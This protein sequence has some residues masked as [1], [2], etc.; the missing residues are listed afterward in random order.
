MQRN[1]NHVLHA[2]V[3]V[4]R[5]VERSLLV[6]DA[7]TR[8]VGA[9]LD[10]ADILRGLA[11]C[12]QPGAQRHGGLY[13]GLRVELGRITDLEQNI[14]HHVGAVRPLE[15]EGP[16]AKEDI[17]KSPVL[18]GEHGGI[19]HLSGPDHEGETNRTAGGI[20]GRPALAG[21]GVGGVAV[22][23]QALPVDPGQRQ[24]IEDLPA[25]QA[26]HLRDHS[27]RGYLDQ[28]D[29]VET[30]LVEGVLQRQAAL[31]LVG[32]DHRRQHRAHGERRRPSATAVRESQSAT[33]RMPP[34]LSEGWPHSA[35]SQV[36]LKSSQ[37]IMAPMLKA[38]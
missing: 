15:A 3:A 34:R 21:T 5:I 11:G 18:G 14:L 9:K 31:D 38:A 29:V 33:A 8:L 37:R 7:E 17:V 16:A 28:H 35:A 10:R 23:P 4:G 12:E 19:T 36:S 20:A 6:D 32:L 2:V 22:S 26:E 24:R 30:N 25:G 13:G 27:G 1:G